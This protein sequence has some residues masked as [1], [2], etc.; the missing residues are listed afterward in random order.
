MIVLTE[1][2]KLQWK[3]LVAL[4]RYVLAQNGANW[5]R[6]REEDHNALHAVLLEDDERSNS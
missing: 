3:A 6:F 1:F 5:V 2:Q 4:S